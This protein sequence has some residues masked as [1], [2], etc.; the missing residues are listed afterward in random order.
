MASKNVAKKKETSVALV[1][2]SILLQD[3]GSGAEG[4][5]SQ[6]FM[7]P[8][9]SIL[10]Q[11]S[12][13]VNKRDGQYVEGAEA[14]DIFNT[15]TRT[16]TQGDKGI[17]VVPIKYR[18]AYI[19]WKPRSSGGGFVRDHGT[20]GS[21][22]D[23][24]EQDPETFRHVTGDGNEIVTTAEYFIFTVNDS[25]VYEPAL[26]SMTGSQLKKAR[27]WNSMMN[28]LKVTL[29]DG[30]VI[31]PALFYSGYQLTTVP[32][33]NDKGTWFG[34]EVEMLHGD[35]GGILENM[36]NGSDIY[37]AARS[38]KDQIQTGQV[39]VAPDQDSSQEEAF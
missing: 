3:Q 20:E 17:T 18:R 9:I 8:R 19:E 22:L 38:F 39:K 14:G 16:A 29:A 37:M 36:D 4:M 26:L 15:V 21:V 2:E 31:S 6:D 27:R 28:Q 7:I 25:G 11:M 35:N 23:N 13:Q 24:C 12:P 34:W 10:Q 32:E 33:E 30:N 1:D 5:D